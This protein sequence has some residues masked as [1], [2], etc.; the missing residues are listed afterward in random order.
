MMLAAAW[1]QSAPFRHTPPGSC[2]GPPVRLRGGL[3]QGPQI[4]LWGLA[5]RQ[6]ALCVDCRAHNRFG[7]FR[8]ARDRPFQ[9]VLPTKTP[10]SRKMA[11]LG[12]RTRETARQIA[13]P[14]G[15]LVALWG[16]FGEYKYENAD[17]YSV[18]V[19]AARR[20]SINEY[21]ASYSRDPKSEETYRSDRFNGTDPNEMRLVVLDIE[22]RNDKSEG[23]EQGYLDSLG[24]ALKSPSHPELWIRTESE[25]LSCSIPQAGGAFQLSIRP[26]TRFTVHVLFASVRHNKPFSSASGTNEAPDLD[27][28][29]YELVLTKAPVHKVIGASV[30]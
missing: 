30:G 1:W 27:A 9:P 28:G 3:R 17:G 26:K 20:M 5:S 6:D 4:S 16:A 8:G 13:H 14:A 22:M 19:G 11:Q 21:L 7:G 18:R 24:W 2:G 10:K 15:D 25:L 23:D 12:K 29:D